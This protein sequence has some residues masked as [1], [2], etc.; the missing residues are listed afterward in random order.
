MVCNKVA[1]PLVGGGASLLYLQRK[2]NTELHSKTTFSTVYYKMD[3]ITASE[4]FSVRYWEL[5]PNFYLQVIWVIYGLGLLLAIK[6]TYPWPTIEEV[7]EREG[8]E[9]WAFTKAISFEDIMFMIILWGMFP[10][11]VAI[12]MD[13]YFF[14]T[15]L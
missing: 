12:G 11:L 10:L 9:H 5:L 8:V 3:Y 13:V 7:M 6:E 2:P 14:I 4:Y 1:P 15:S